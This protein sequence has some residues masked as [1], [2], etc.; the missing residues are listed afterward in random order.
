M[1]SI[2]AA[3]TLEADDRLAS[4]PHPT[5]PLAYRSSS[6]CPLNV[7]G[8]GSVITFRTAGRSAP[9]G[10]AQ[11]MT[12]PPSKARGASR[13]FRRIP[14]LGQFQLPCP[15]QPAGSGRSPQCREEAS[16][17]VRHRAARSVPRSAPKGHSLGRSAPPPGRQQP[18]VRATPE[19]AERE[20]FTCQPH[21]LPA[22]FLLSRSVP[23][24]LV[25]FHLVFLLPSC[26][27]VPFA[28]HFSVASP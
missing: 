16:H 24:L 7:G 23:S 25:T 21:L 1:S 28:Q 17:K 12:S 2:A 26:R 22:T 6:N 15:A 9:L 14:H 8:C 18:G 13:L 10:K 3:F 20:G 19:A 27:T 11:G 5:T 4:Q